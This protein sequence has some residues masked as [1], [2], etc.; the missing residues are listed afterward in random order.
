MIPSE[1]LSGMLVSINN[2]GYLRPEGY[3]AHAVAMKLS[4][5]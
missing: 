1:A 5:C 4:V 3:M 2:L